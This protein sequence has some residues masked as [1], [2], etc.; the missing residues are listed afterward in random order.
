M[1]V[2]TFVKRFM[3][4]AVQKTQEKSPVFLTLDVS[5][6]FKNLKSKADIP[7]R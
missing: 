1:S 4:T 7:W 6:G 3:K 5:F 2:M